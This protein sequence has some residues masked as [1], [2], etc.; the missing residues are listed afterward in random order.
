MTG[1][2]TCALPIFITPRIGT[3]YQCKRAQLK[4]VRFFPITNFQSYIIYYR[5]QPEGIQIIRILHGHMDKQR[6][7]EPEK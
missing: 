3:L 6:H 2:Q 4:G 5:E 7:L 1:V